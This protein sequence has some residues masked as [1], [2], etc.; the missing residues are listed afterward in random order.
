MRDQRCVGEC[1]AEEM[2]NLSQIGMRAAVVGLLGL[3]AFAVGQ[4]CG[5]DTDDGGNPDALVSACESY[6]EAGLAQ[7]CGENQATESQCKAQCAFLPT[8]T[9]GFCENEAA[10]TFECAAEGGFTCMG[11]DTDGDGVDDTQTPVPNDQCVTQA[12]AYA[13]CESTAGCGR[14][15]ASA[16]DEGC[17]GGCLEACEGRQAEIEAQT[18]N[19]GFAYNSYASCGGL[20]GV[21]CD[22]GDAR[23][24]DDC[25]DAAFTVGECLNPDAPDLCPSYC[26]GAEE[27][28]CTSDCATVCA[29]NLADP[30]CGSQWNSLLDCVTFFGDASCQNGL[31]LPTSDGICSSERDAYQ[32]CTGG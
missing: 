20:L 29:A 23:P 32:S 5:D 12:Q 9:K 4:G 17:G 1:Y 8:Q 18:A 13:T 11:I 3:A 7:P 28:G 30:T 31:V 6:C 22:G 21:Q 2:L 14:F 15:C 24:G 26:F 19:C 10:A 25:L 27:I 16:D